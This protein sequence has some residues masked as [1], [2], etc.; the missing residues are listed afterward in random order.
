MK[1]SIDWVQAAAQDLVEHAVVID[2]ETTGLG[3]NDTVVELAVVDAKSRTVIFDSLIVPYSPC[4]PAA[5]KTHGINMAHATD[6]G[7]EPHSALVDLLGLGTIK[8]LAA[9]NMPF[10]RRL[11]LQTA[12]ASGVSKTVISGLL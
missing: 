2:T 9:Y 6:L 4:H 8:H 7:Q 11:L 12:Y 3:E 1:K 5:A 10:D